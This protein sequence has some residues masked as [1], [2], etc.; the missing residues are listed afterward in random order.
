MYLP[1]ILT[2]DEYL[3][4]ARTLKYIQEKDGYIVTIAK[5]SDINKY[6]EAE[7][8]SI[9]GVIGY[10]EA[11]KEEQELLTDYKFSLS[12]KIIS[13]LRELLEDNKINYLTILGD[14]S[15][16]PPSYYVISPDY[17]ND[18][19]QW[20]PTD[21]FYSGPNTK[22]KI[23]TIEISVGRLPFRDRDEARNIIN[24]IKLYRE[25]LNES[26]FKNIGLMGGDPFDGDY[27]GE[28]MLADGVNKDYLGGMNVKKLFRTSGK[29]D[30]K[31]VLKSL[32]DEDYGIIWEEGHGGG[33]TLYLE[34]GTL[35]SKEILSLPQKNKLP[36]FLSVACGN[37][38]Y[39][40]RVLK[41]DFNTNKYLKYPTSFSEALVLS[42]G[43]AIAYVGGARINY[44][45][46]SLTYKNGIPELKNKMYMDLILDIFMSNYN[47]K[48]GS[49]GDI[50]KKTLTDYVKKGWRYINYGDIK[51]SD[52]I[53]F[54]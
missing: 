2:S 37:G 54:Q 15:I 21:L 7:D 10:V 5:V 4:E 13:Y 42:N 40:T 53:C 31:S 11:S 27:I 16:I 18:Y 35:D 47:N 12:K 48:E 6:S 14:G 17:F 39:D 49:L 30:R 50:A 45:G 33:D 38:A 25:S 36:I 9:T 3:E 19:D 23:F 44:S 8:P 51:V 29:F 26:W 43:G 46:F 24:K 41:T 22:G 32:T 52:C 20:V 34:P 28:L 1:V